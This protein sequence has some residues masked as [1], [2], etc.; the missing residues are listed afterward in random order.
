MREP[1]IPENTVITPLAPME[2]A[3]IANAFACVQA[4]HAR[5]IDTADA[6]AADIG[7]GIL[8][9]L[10][11]DVAA[12]VCIPVT[13]DDGHDGEPCVHSFL[14]AAPGRRLLEAVGLAG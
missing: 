2:P 10:L 6:V 7:P 3:D 9:R 13:A 1:P 11:L 12:R 5:D 14:A 8:F 4:W